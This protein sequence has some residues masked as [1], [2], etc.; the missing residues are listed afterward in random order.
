[1]KKTVT[2][3]E[4]QDAKAEIIRGV[5]CKEFSENSNGRTVKTYAAEN[6]HTFHEVTENG[7]TEF[8]STKHSTSRYYDDR[9]REEII[10]EY[11]KKISK[12]NE[13]RNDLRND[14]NKN[15]VEVIH[16]RKKVKELEEKIEAINAITAA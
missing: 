13:D 11:E 6:G 5:E 2:L 16:L 8:W 1:M 15:G 10:A 14:M 4:Y 3:K 9:T 12:L 7:I